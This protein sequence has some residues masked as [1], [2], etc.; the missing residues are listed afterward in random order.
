LASVFV[1]E[2]REDQANDKL[3][4]M[5]SEE[6][7]INETILHIT[8]KCSLNVEGYSW[9]WLRNFAS[10]TAW[11]EGIKISYVPGREIVPQRMMCIGMKG[12]RGVTEK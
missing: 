3:Y 1:E 4:A 2:L 11:E 9:E 10:Y 8:D 5:T 6:D 12:A 7:T